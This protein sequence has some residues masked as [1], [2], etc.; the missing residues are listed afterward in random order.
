MR[1]DQIILASIA[2]GT[3]LLYAF[4]LRSIGER[5]VLISERFELDTRPSAKKRKTYE[6]SIDAPRPLARVPVRASTTI[7]DECGDTK[8]FVSNARCKKISLHPSAAAAAVE[9][10]AQT[11]VV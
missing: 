2:G 6:R 11:K 9:Y 5:E 4:H 10:V 7:Y 8:K 3:G 1:T